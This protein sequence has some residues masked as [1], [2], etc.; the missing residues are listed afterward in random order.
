MMAMFVPGWLCSSVL[1]ERAAEIY[2][3]LR[4]LPV[5]DR[6]VVR[7]KFGLTLAAAFS[8]GASCP[9]DQFAGNQCPD[10]S[11]YMALANLCV[12]VALPLAGFCYVFHWRFGMS[13]LTIGVS[14]FVVCASLGH[15]SSM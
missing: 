15:S 10:A 5:T 4:G 3:F 1:L 12:A 6:E 7:T 14:A 11:A 13:A 2:A 9:P 8:T